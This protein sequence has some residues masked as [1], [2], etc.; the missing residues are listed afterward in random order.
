[1]IK[2]TTVILAAAV[3]ARCS[4]GAVVKV[5]EDHKSIRAAIDVASA[6]DTIL[7][8]PGTYV[9]ESTLDVAKVLTIA[10]DY[11]NSKDDADID[12]TIIKSR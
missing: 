1:M 4:Y 8:A 7:L 12:A 6:G 11:I 2:Y 9:I 10:S 3:F 5:P